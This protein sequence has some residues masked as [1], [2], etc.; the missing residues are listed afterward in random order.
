MRTSKDTDP[1]Q[2]PSPP[3]PTV[4]PKD[5][6]YKKTATADP[7]ALIVL[8]TE[9]AAAAE[10]SKANRQRRNTNEKK[11]PQSQPQQQQQPKS[12]STRGL[13]FWRSSEERIRRPSL[14]K[15]GASS[16][17][18]LRRDAKSSVSVPR[19]NSVTKPSS[20]TPPPT[21][22]SEEDEVDDIKKSLNLL[23]FFNQSKQQRVI[24]M[25]GSDYATLDQCCQVIKEYLQQQQSTNDNDAA[26][27]AFH[28][29]QFLIDQYEW[30]SHIKL[31]SWMKK[32]D[33]AS[34][35]FFV[36]FFG[37]RSDLSRQKELEN[38]DVSLFV[39]VR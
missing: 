38:A 13:K 3:P 21:P 29:I 31:E 7:A 22:P 25:E 5:V 33:M 9:A 19:P 36:C 24:G 28:A 18:S 6:Q 16:F 26:A 32:N 34:F 39:H 1:P 20:S 35:N 11:Q 14:P 23:Q 4:P 10:V 15:L 8:P 17:R 27:T 30:P 2:P 12:S 37:G